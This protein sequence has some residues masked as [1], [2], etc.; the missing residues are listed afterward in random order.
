METIVARR[1]IRSCSWAVLAGIAAGLIVY[2]LTGRPE[3]GLTL[4]LLLAAG[5]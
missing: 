3:S 4:G 2:R 1:S 5:P